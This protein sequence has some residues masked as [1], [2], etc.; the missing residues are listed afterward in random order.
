VSGFAK[1]LNKFGGMENPSELPPAPTRG[2]LEGFIQRHGGVTEEFHFYHD[3][4]TL[5]FDKE[6]HIYY[7]VN[8]LGNLTP[9]DGVTQTCSIIDKSHA[10]V[11]WAAKMV[12]EKLLRIIPTET[13]DN[14]ISLRHLTLDEFS[15]FALD[16]K[17]A[18]KEKLESAGDIGRAAHQCLEDSIKHAIVESGQTV[19][20][21]VNLPFDAQA[22]HC[23]RVALAWMQTHKVRWTDTERKIYSREWN[24]AG[25]LDAIAYVSSCD[26]RACCPEAFEDRLCLIDFKTS[27]A[28]R[29]DYC[30]QVAAYQ[31]AIVEEMGTPIKSRIILRLGKD[32][33]DFQPWFL[34][35]ET[36]AEDLSGFLTCLRLT[37]IM[38]SIEERMKSQRNNIKTIKKAQKDT[39]KALAKEQ[40]KLQKALDKA[41]AKVVREEEKAKIKILAKEAR[42][43]AKQAKINLP[44]EEK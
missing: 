24:F 18:H 26:D 36:F 35:E 15:R 21:L 12:V 34:P 29:T 25:T 23:A 32:S 33:G 8:E 22:E 41:A 11:P 10:L 3:T 43:A 31:Q 9:V 7:R 16:A 4:V 28:L 19:Q 39:A 6:E 42:D 5:R 37:R 13:V 20:T 30:L 1:L 14:V 44:M 2:G 17:G 38:D 27:N 40:E